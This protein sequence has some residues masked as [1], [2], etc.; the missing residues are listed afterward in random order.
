M[1]RTRVAAAGSPASSASA[2]A[3]ARSSDD[4]AVSSLDLLDADLGAR[5]EFERELLQL[6]Q[7][8]LLAVADVRDQR[9]G[10]VG[11]PASS[12]SSAARAIT[13][14]GSSHG[15]TFSSALTSPP[16]PRTASSEPLGRLHAA[17]LA[18]EERDR[19]V[20][21]DR[22]ERDASSASRSFSFHRSTP[23][24]MMNRRPIANVIAFSAAAIA[25]GVLAS[26]SN[27]STPGGAALGLGE[28]P[29][30]GAPLGDPTVVVAV[31]QVGGLER[32]GTSAVY[33]CIRQ[34]QT[35][36]VCC[37]GCYLIR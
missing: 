12:C 37:R 7:Q 33:G 20:R 10:G 1:S 16:A 5:P 26:P 6:A 21:R 2:S 15:L 13:H 34:P 8:P 24:T 19:R 18:R 28:R 30:A 25:S 9:A 14:F 23:S 17:V 31:D 32:G 35:A 4:G 11:R 36:C 22:G 27:S 29:Q 3:Q